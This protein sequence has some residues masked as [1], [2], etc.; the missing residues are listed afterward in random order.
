MR[1]KAI[2]FPPVVTKSARKLVLG[3]MPGLKSLEVQQYYAHPQNAFWY[4]MSQLYDAP[5]DTYS[6]RMALVRKNGIA[7][8]E[9]LKCCER[10]GSL[11]TRIDD[12]TIEVNDFVSFFM[13][14]PD[15]THVYLNGGKAAKEFMKRVLP[16]LPEDIAAR[17][18]LHPMPSTSPA[19][20]GMKKADK[21]KA[22]RRILKD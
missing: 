4:I 12:D 20:A 21:V 5:I 14:Y 16:A 6:Q 11:D 15:I 1:H 13:A 8:W 2:S 9:V 7:L 22:W 19:H 18:K 10:H 3:S 17:L